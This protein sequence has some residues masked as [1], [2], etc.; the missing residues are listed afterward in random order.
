MGKTNVLA[1]PRVLVLN[2]QRAEIQLGHRLGY[3]TLVTN[4]TSTV[5]QIQFLNTGT[6]LRLRPFISDDGM[7]RMEIHP[8]RST[9]AIDANGVPQTNTARMTT[10]VLVPNGATLVIGGLIENQD[11][12]T[13]RAA[14]P[15]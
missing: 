11:D 7:I 8:E 2:K 9:G 10:N 13:T 5:Q 3:R 1:T 4:L 12:V 15:A 14:C 6:L